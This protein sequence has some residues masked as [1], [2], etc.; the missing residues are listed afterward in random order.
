MARSVNLDGR[1]FVASSTSTN[2]SGNWCG[3][4]HGRQQKQC[5]TPNAKA[6][7]IASRGFLPKPALRGR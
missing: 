4:H 6:E 3:L 1:T 7:L 2:T 5:R